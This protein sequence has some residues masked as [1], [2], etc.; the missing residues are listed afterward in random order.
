MLFFLH[1]TTFAES[2]SIRIVDYPRHIHF[3]S[4]IGPTYSEVEIV[5][6]EMEDG[7]LFKPNP[8]PVIGLGFSYSWFGLGFSFTVPSSEVQVKKYGKTQKFDFE[9]HYTLRKLMIDLTLKNYKGFYF[10]NPET[11]IDTWNWK[12]DP[13]PQVPNLET[14]TAGVSFAYIF[15]PERYSSNAAYTFTQSMRKSGGSWM[16][17]GFA[18]LNLMNSDSSIVPFSVRQHVD[19]KLDLKA[20]G[21]YNVGASFGYS[22]L[23]RFRKNFFIAFTLLPGL[24]LQKVYLQS[25]IDETVT[26]SNELALRTISRF[27]VGRNGNKFFWGFRINAFLRFRP[28][29]IFLRLPP[30]YIRMEVYE[31]N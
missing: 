10:S 19:P 20:V 5:N 26:E 14:F 27:S 7:L 8:E 24:S 25:S 29:R 4:K 6:L 31:K 30:R 11:Y 16:L 18:S 17:G 21:F 23:F 2:D 3:Y 22:H 15:K 28:Y 12:T 13:Y 1:G 9:A